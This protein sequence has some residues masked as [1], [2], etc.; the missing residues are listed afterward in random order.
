MTYWG[1]WDLYH[2]NN[3]VY[4]NFGEEHYEKWHKHKQQEWLEEEYRL[5][6]VRL[7]EQNNI[8]QRNM[9]LPSHFSYYPNW[10]NEFHFWNKCQYGKGSYMFTTVQDPMFRFALYGRDIT[11]N[12]FWPIEKWHRSQRYIADNLYHYFFLYVG[13]GDRPKVHWLFSDAILEVVPDLWLSKYDFR[14]SYF[15][16]IFNVIKHQQHYYAQNNTNG[17][18]P[19]YYWDLFLPTLKN[20]FIHEMYDYFYWSSGYWSSSYYPEWYSIWSEDTCHLDTRNVFEFYLFW[21][22]THFEK[23]NYSYDVFLSSPYAP[24]FN[25]S[26]HYSDSFLI[27]A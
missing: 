12:F 10:S 27:W 21:C 17:I 22:S 3:Y 5:T 20:G 8:Y 9:D 23:N 11:R 14:K 25:K 13:E 18:T 16:S 26:S 7:I 2:Q 6:I 24:F 4:Y 1:C 15:Y 19:S